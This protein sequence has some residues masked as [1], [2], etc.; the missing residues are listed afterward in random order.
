MTTAAWAVQS[1]AAIRG[2][3]RHPAVQAL[4]FLASDALAVF[5]AGAVAVLVRY[6]LGG[7]FELSMY[8]RMSV[9]TGFFVLAYAALGLY[10]AVIL[11]PVAEL[12]GIVRGTTLTVLL[13]GTL[14]FFQRD[15]E[16][17]SR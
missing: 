2:T 16:A 17:Y 3:R 5:L 11:H 10:P 1:H 6:W 13:L 8:L 7:Q 15:A 9:V 12:Q 4:P 14:T